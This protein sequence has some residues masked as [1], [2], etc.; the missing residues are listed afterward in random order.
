MSKNIEED[1]NQC[2]N[3]GR[4]NSTD[5][6]Y[7][8][9]CG[10]HLMKIS[11][12]RLNN[13]YL[14][15][16]K[17]FL[18][19]IVN[20]DITKENDTITYH[21][22][23]LEEYITLMESYIL[24]ITDIQ[25]KDMNKIDYFELI[26]NIKNN[27]EIEDILERF[28]VELNKNINEV[29]PKL[30]EKYKVKYLF[31]TNIKQNKLKK[32]SNE[33]LI[34]LLRIFNLKIF[35]PNNIK[36]INN[37]KRDLTYVKLK[38]YKEV[39]IISEKETNV[40]NKFDEE[41]K[42]SEKIFTIF[43][44]IDFLIENR[45]Y[46]NTIIKNTYTNKYNFSNLLI[47]DVLYLDEDNNFT[48]IPDL[49]IVNN[50][51]K[52]TE[53]ND[54]VNEI[55]ID[56][57]KEI[58]ENNK[59]IKKYI[60]DYF[61]TYHFA[62]IESN[63]DNSFMKFWSLNEK[64]IKNI[65][66]KINDEKLVEI[67]EKI[68]LYYN[69]STLFVNRI[70]FLKNKRNKYVHESKLNRITEID[71]NIIK[72]ITDHLIRFILNNH[73]LVNNIN[74]YKYILKYENNPDSLWKITE[75][76]NKIFVVELKNENLNKKFTRGKYIESPENF[77]KFQFKSIGI[78]KFDIIR[79]KDLEKIQSFINDDENEQEFVKDLFF[80]QLMDINTEFIKKHKYDN[81]SDIELK[82]FCNCYFNYN[83]TSNS[84]ISMKD[85]YNCI[86]SVVKNLKFIS[87]KN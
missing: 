80:N 73:Y 18:E 55:Y 29:N 69:H 46:K 53:I 41:R 82:N 2:R 11:F 31:Y 30:L 65:Y 8:M 45:R 86:K 42:I 38:K 24:G 10:K 81:I 67:M 6:F 71:R 54:N 57:Y 87:D 15:N 51:N 52:P 13:K 7:C 14:K 28:I 4:S 84:N 49:S 58:S 12:K 32:N 16:F 35:N 20:I 9:Y 48:D 72:V 60:D 76:I 40:L 62:C 5:A 74:D 68:L 44:F 23:Y 79:V 25:E 50:E 21:G 64:I 78:L 70:I 63:L 36:L 39:I 27:I 33:L 66:G 61:L 37:E 34:K 75:V 17:K 83:Y 77:M 26:Y 1:Q 56:K 59:R 19:E 85:F 43:G 3:C 47:N 22:F